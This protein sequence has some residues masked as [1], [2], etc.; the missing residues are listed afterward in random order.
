MEL[1]IVEFPRYI[2][3]LSQDFDHLFQQERQRTHFKQLMTGYV[4]AERKTITHMNGLF[5]VHTDQSNLNRFVTHSEWDQMKMNKVKIDMINQVEHEGI[6][7]LDDMIVEKYGTEIY[8][9]DYHY[10]HSSGRTVQGW[11]IADCVYSGKGIY[12]LLSSLYIRKNSRWL[13]KQKDFKSKIDLQMDHLNQLVD[14]NLSFSC[15]VVDIWYFSKKLTQHIESLEKDWI[16]AAKSNRQV[17]SKRQWISLRQFA[18]KMINHTGFKPVELGDKKYLMKAFTV[19]TK[20]MGKVRVLVSLNDHGNFRFYVTNRLDWSELDIATRFSR[21]WDIE[22][23]HRD[24]KGSYGVEDCQLRSDEGVSRHLT[25]SMLADTL[26]EI[27]SL[28]SPMYAMLKNQS[29]TPELKHRWVL[30]ELVRQLISSVQK[31]GG[32]KKIKKIMESILLPYKST[33]KEG[34]AG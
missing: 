22:V 33:M 10:D 25:L 3:E 7:V 30:T 6:V 16:A 1:P 4:L 8:G 17:K 28:L 14:M 31:R 5:T 27:A 34:S 32:D 12:P 21:R 20:N 24:G 9:V 19:Y 15:V 11:Q 2:E 23:W 13:K 26:L 29:W 18:E